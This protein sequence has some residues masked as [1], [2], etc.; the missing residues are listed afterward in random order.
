L[1]GEA[2]HATHEFYFERAAITK[3]LIAEKAFTVVAIEA[4]PVTTVFRN[5]Q[6]GNR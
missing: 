4:N 3:R 2:S 1:F 6:V 5:I